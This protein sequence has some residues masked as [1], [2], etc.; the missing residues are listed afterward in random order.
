MPPTITE[1]TTTPP[2]VLPPNLRYIVLASIAGLVLVTSFFSG[3][4]GKPTTNSPDATP[5]AG[6]VPA[7]LSMFTQ[8]L[9]KQRRE[10]EEARRQFDAAHKAEEQNK[11]L[12]LRTAPASYGV[13]EPRVMNAPLVDPL[14]LRRREREEQALFLGS[15]ALTVLKTDDKPRVEPPLRVPEAGQELAGS[16]PHL[17]PEQIASAA[18]KSIGS[19]KYLSEKENGLY[20]VYE[21]TF[22]ETTLANRLDGSFTGPVKCIV[23]KDVR[24]K[25]GEAVLIPKG[26]QLF[27][28]AKRVESAGQ[29]RLAVTFKRLLLPDGYSV[30]LGNAPGL[31][32][33]GETGL[34]DKTNNHY[35]RTFGISGA[36]GLLGG[37]ALYGGRAASGYEYATGVANTEGSAATTILNRSLN[38]LPTITI[39]EGHTVNVYLS[40]DLQMPEYRP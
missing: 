7:Q 26:S 2:G 25:T 18:K 34:K 23:S 36:V 6:A 31:N 14:E 40:A 8:M 24:S 13:P 15:I 4:P 29:T 21:G 33:E 11:L 17:L 19:G 38:L 22:I 1:K 12:A 10:A 28:E 5:P 20:R 32:R 35:L 30:D 3:R 16:G 37:L 27:G 9:E 39:R